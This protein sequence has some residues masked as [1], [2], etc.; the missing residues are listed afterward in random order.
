MST[1]YSPKIAT[2]G[3]VYYLDAGNSKS[4][5]GTGTTWSNLNRTGN[6]GTLTAGP[7]FSATNGGII[8]FN[9]STNYVT[10]TRPSSIVTGGSISI[11]MWAKWLS[12]GTTTSTI[13]TLLDNN[14]SGNPSQG[15]Y[16]Q[17][18]PD[19]SKY[20]TFGVRPQANSAIST[21]QVGDGTWHHI[22]GT[23]DLTTSRLYID[24]KLN[25]SFTETS[26]L[27]TVQPNVT[28][29]RSQLFGRYLNGSI[30]RVLMYSRA[31]TPAEVLLD[32]NAT[33]GRFGL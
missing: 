2:D 18:R 31:I 27:T 13:Q 25:N 20:L 7:T 24:G 33:K 15:F 19:L 3:L 32:Y 28:I 12:T 10:S 1:Y 9:G 26:G 29:G 23:N 17:D 14:H 22:A 8:V 5:P 21:F 6:D 4:Y 11:V 16:I 30:S